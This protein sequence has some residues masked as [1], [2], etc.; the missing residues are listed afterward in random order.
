MLAVFAGHFNHCIL[1]ANK[2]VVYSTEGGFG[3]ITEFGWSLEGTVG[4]F[5]IGKSGE[6]VPDRGKGNTQTC[7]VVNR[8][9]G[10]GEPTTRVQV[11]GE[12]WSEMSWED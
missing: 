5:Q 4:G 1:S 7:G 8:H 2:S 10:D 11:A 12:L 3:V 9:G 6:N